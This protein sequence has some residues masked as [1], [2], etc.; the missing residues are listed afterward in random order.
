MATACVLHWFVGGGGGG[1]GA[2]RSSAGKTFINLKTTC[3][4]IGVGR[5]ALVRFLRLIFVWLFWVFFFLFSIR[6]EFLEMIHIN[7]YLRT[8]KLYDEI[9][10]S[11]PNMKFVYCNSC[12]YCVF[13]K[14]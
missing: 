14:M 13:N 2:G 7:Q 5:L 10:V 11:M 3:K 9:N 6:C 4:L 1:G 12:T 8:C